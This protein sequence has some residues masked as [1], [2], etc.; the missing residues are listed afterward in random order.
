MDTWN[1]YVLMVKNNVAN[2]R[3]RTTCQMCT[4]CPF[5][6]SPT[7]NPRGMWSMSSASPILLHVL[8]SVSW[9]FSEYWCIMGNWRNVSLPH[10]CYNIFGGKE[11][12]HVA[13]HYYAIFACLV[14]LHNPPC[15]VLELGKN[16]LYISRPCSPLV[17]ISCRDCHSAWWWVGLR[18][19]LTVCPQSLWRQ[20]RS[21]LDCI[22]QQ[23]PNTCHRGNYLPSG[24]ECVKGNVKH[25][26]MICVC[27]PYNIH[28]HW[29]STYNWSVH[30]QMNDVLIADFKMM[31][32]QI[33]YLQYTGNLIISM[34]NMLKKLMQFDMKSRILWNYKSKHN[35]RH[36]HGMS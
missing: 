4:P 35:I 30:A 1:E 32:K 2:H 8:S 27:I 12:D 13:I 31:L 21:H 11:Y 6:Q 33:N 17:G 5:A 36:M 18:F 15:Q 34:T 10:N 3:Y 29:I 23:C 7:S 26:A 14:P 22:W 25:D 28:V 16:V 24:A 19:G 9:L 20:S